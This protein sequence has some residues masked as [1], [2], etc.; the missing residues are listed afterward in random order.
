MDPEQ[1]AD[2]LLPALKEMAALTIKV[3]RLDLHKALLQSKLPLTTGEVE[4]L[5]E[6]FCTCL[7]HCKKRLR[8]AGSGVRLP[9]SYVC[10]LGVWKKHH[11]KA[12]LKSK[13]SSLKKKLQEEEGETKEQ[14]GK[15]QV[16]A[17][18]GEGKQHIRDVFGLPMK[19]KMV[20]VDLVSSSSGSSFLE[21]ARQPKNPNLSILSQQLLHQ[22]TLLERYSYFLSVQYVYIHMYICVCV[23]SYLCTLEVEEIEEL[24]E[25][26]LL[27]NSFPSKLVLQVDHLCPR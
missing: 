3:R 23:A 13:K 8:D 10:L 19:Q 6:K 21:E 16:E 15:L 26:D 20:P 27:E 25:E 4:L 5:V 2:A 11:G 24:E 12:S 9:K 22:R 7:K 18:E 14:E 17:K 1:F